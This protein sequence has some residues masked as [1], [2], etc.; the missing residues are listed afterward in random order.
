MFG[1]NGVL[2][3]L[4]LDRSF[5][6]AFAIVAALFCAGTV[7]PYVY[8]ADDHTY[9][10]QAD[11]AAFAP[12]NSSPAL[13]DS[14]LDKNFT[15]TNSSGN[16]RN[17]AEILEAIRSRKD[18]EL[19]TGSVAA[20]VHGQVGI[21]QENTDQVY[22]LRVWIKRGAR[23]RLLIYQAVS[24]G[25]PPSAASDN[26]Q[27]ENPCN[28]VP[29]HPQSADEADV[30]HAYQAVERAVTAHDSAAWGAHIADEF[31]AV[32]SNS[33]RPVDKKTRIAGLDNQKVGGIAPF[34]LVS[35]RMFEYGDTMVMTSHQQP[36][37]GLPLHVT[38]VWF[39]RNNVWLEAFSY[40]TTILGELLLPRS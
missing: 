1:M 38:R 21:I 40:Q 20:H 37:H 13:N 11:Q 24:I 9:L 2:K 17:K 39:K 29:F 4:S 34:P 35:A 26:E 30:I 25:G 12:G 36:L 7:V 31:F 10:L 6:V 32:T 8:S 16:T 18:L 27:C 33:D 28:R 5:A 14:T 15:W 22:A 19:I 23:W 3:N